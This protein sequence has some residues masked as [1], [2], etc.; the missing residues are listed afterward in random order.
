MKN[1]TIEMFRGSLKVAVC[2]GF[3]YYAVVLFSKAIVA[4]M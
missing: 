4:T 3:M 1:Y 2:L